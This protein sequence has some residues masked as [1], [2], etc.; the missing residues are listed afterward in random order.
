MMDNYNR[1]IDDALLFF[2]LILV[3]L[4]CNSNIFGIGGC[5]E[6]ERECDYRRKC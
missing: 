3:L 1:G 6:Q 4:F 2:F 5:G